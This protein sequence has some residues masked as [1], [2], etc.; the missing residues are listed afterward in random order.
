MKRY[1]YGQRPVAEALKAGHVQL[2]LVQDDVVARE[3]AELEKTAQAGRV[4]IESRTR[5][6]LDALVDGALHQRVVAI[7]GDYAYAS[8]E[9]ILA[10]AKKSGRPP[11]LLLLDSVQDPQNLGALV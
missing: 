6:E 7:V 9:Q 8:V 5:A 10:V 4:A 11:L 2:L 3:R 1:I